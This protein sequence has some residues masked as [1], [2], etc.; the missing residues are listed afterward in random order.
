[1]AARESDHEEVLSDTRGCRAMARFKF[2]LAALVVAFVSGRLLAADQKT[3]LL[4]GQSPDGHPRATHEYM[5]G[6]EL[7]AKLLEPTSGL[8]VTTV[9]ADE[10]WSDGPRVL[11]EV[12][13][14][15]L[16][17]SEGA[18]WTQAD[19]RRRD[20]LARLAARGGGFIALHWAMGTKSAEPI[21][22]FLKLLGGCHGGPDRKY[23]VVET[24]LRI[25][26]PAHPVAAGLEN[27][28]VRDEFYYQLKLVGPPQ[29]VRSLLEAAIDG[30]AETVAWT[31]ER[32]DGGR[33]FGFTGLHFHENWNLPQYRKLVAGAVLWTLDLPVAR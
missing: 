15:V 30:R 5:A 25:A 9:Q 18:R 32:P 13:G 2:I 12:D 8:K 26:D 4:V 24:E 19:P 1:M 27:F 23:R 7:L 28:R 11:G 6:V 16:F 33:S 31:W 20:A 10:P 17:L 3:V 29:G 14:V 21:E 22:P